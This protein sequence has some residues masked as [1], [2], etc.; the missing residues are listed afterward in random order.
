LMT[1]TV[2]WTSNEAK[3]VIITWVCA[4]LGDG[5]LWHHLYGITRRKTSVTL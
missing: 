4:I 1:S 3:L 5:G 2:N